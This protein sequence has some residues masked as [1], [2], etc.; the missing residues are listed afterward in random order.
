MILLDKTTDATLWNN[1][2]DAYASDPSADLGWANVELTKVGTNN[3]SGVFIENYEAVGIETAFTAGTAFDG[4]EGYF[5]GFAVDVT[6]LVSGVPSDKID[7]QISG[8]KTIYH[9][10]SLDEGDEGKKYVTSLLE[11]P[12]AKRAASIKITVDGKGYEYKV[13]VRRITFDGKAMYNGFVYDGKQY[14]EGE[15]LWNLGGWGCMEVHK[16]GR[17]D[18][19]A[20]NESADKLPPYVVLGSTA[21]NVQTSD[22]YQ[23][24]KDGWAK[25]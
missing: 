24:T 25:Y 21:T 13:D 15:T 1:V 16:D 18:Y 6:D 7:I 4:K 3:I 23:M 20:K 19:I 22:V 12:Y 10:D 14:R 11:L 17:R 8:N 9:G 5:I 2:K